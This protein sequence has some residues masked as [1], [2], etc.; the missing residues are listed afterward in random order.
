[1]QS[2]RLFRIGTEAL[3]VAAG[4]LAAFAGGF[5]A[6]KLLSGQL[7][8]AM[9][10]QL[11]LGISAAGVLH[12]FVY[13]PIEQVALRFV[14]VYRERNQLALLFTS[15]EKIHIYAALF[16]VAGIAF[17]VSAMQVFADAGWSMLILCALLFGLTGGINT[18]LSSLQSALRQRASVAFFQAS[19][20]W[21]RLLLACAASVNI[22][23]FRLELPTAVTQLI[24]TRRNRWSPS[25]RT[26]RNR[27]RYPL[28]GDIGTCNLRRPIRICSIRLAQHL[29][30]RW[31]YGLPKMKNR[32]ASTLCCFRLRMP[33]S[34]IHGVTNQSWYLLS[35]TVGATKHR[36]Q[37]LAAE[38]RHI[39]PKR[40]QASSAQR[41]CRNTLVACANE[42]SW[43]RDSLLADLR[44]LSF[45]ALTFGVKGQS[46]GRPQDYVL[47]K[48]IQF[49]LLLV[50]I[51]TLI[52]PLALTG[53]ALS[54][55]ISGAG[56][57]AAVIVVNRRL[58][59][60][61]I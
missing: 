28:K 20:V 32:S 50:S 36:I 23:G 38:C 19:D 54:L 48:F 46:Y 30:N 10:G 13:G 31:A 34:H 40:W 9:Y 7:G 47:P 2:S 3:W 58:H 25:S 41:G 52:K 43:L 51:L 44:Q 22:A 35:L 37:R 12:M 16:V 55:C 5:A 14:S 17:A 18:T 42:F 49:A 59:P 60:R 11:A 4:Q 6:I 33:P 61:G 1:M 53:V 45:P 26:D 15:L 21:L 57:L 56:Y 24:W 8:P 39:I 27:I 29:R